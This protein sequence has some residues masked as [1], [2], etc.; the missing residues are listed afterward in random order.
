MITQRAKLRRLAFILRPLCPRRPGSPLDYAG[1]FA[2]DSG[3]VR[4]QSRC[5]TGLLPREL[6]VSAHSSAV[7]PRVGGHICAWLRWC[8]RPRFCKERG[9]ARSIISRPAASVTSA[10]AR[11]RRRRSGASSGLSIR[12]VHSAAH[13]A[14]SLP[15]CTAPSLPVSATARPMIRSATSAGRRRNISASSTIGP[16]PLQPPSP[17]A[18]SP[19][20]LRHRRRIR[21][22]PRRAAAA[23]PTAPACAHR[24]LRPPAPAS[25]PANA[26]G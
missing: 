20:P 3:S 2:A 7:W 12:I 9:G 22:S 19:P 1:D 24:D 15:S 18:Q 25:I 13:S 26:A 10:P 5:R 21:W 17:P 4:E 23:A 6:P 16:L 14:S 11:V 8:W